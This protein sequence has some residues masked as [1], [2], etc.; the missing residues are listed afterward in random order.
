MLIITS[1]EQ[2]KSEL[3]KPEVTLHT[4]YTYIDKL[5]TK[6]VSIYS[7]LGRIMFNLALPE[8]YL[9]V[10]KVID[11]SALTTII[12]D[13][14]EKYD[15][16]VVAETMFQ[17]NKL[18][19]FMGTVCPVTFNVDSFILPSH[20]QEEKD[21]MLVPGLTPTEFFKR[22]KA[23]GVDLL[24]YFK[25]TNNGL[26]DIIK[27]GAKGNVDDLTVLLVAK[28]SAVSLDG[29][30]SIPTSNS[31]N[32][33]FNLDEF[34]ANADESRSGLFTRSSGAALPGALARDTVYANANILLDKEDCKTKKYLSLL[35]KD[36]MKNLIIGRYYLDTNT[37]N[38]QEI[39]KDH[40]LVGKIISLRS[41]FYCISE[42]G[43]CP[44]C[45]GRLGEKLD[46]THVG[47]MTG[48]IIN[49]VLLNKT[50]KARH[51]SSNVS[52]NKVNFKEDLIRV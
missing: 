24:E 19:F 36:D 12:N 44:I 48:S 13:L 40:K 51:M 11:K 29:I 10:D 30:P 7:Q 3:E 5:K 32:T 42:K 8:D 38:L 35:I 50:M 23:I 28:G 20:I 15:S 41:P 14:L 31:I 16:Q 49:D 9:Y 37:G 39:K 21:K 47:V 4:K 33:G 34:M 26:Y 1:L 22:A 18:A 46:T 2:A 43:V 25:E 27:S 52:A 45:Y 6:N 17:I